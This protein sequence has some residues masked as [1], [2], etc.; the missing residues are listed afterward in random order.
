MLERRLLLTEL[1]PPAPSRRRARIFCVLLVG[2][3]CG[4]E[5]GGGGGVE[6]RGGA[7]CGGVQSNYR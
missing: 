6:L 4:C 7:G 1:A 5:E 2:Q 3:C